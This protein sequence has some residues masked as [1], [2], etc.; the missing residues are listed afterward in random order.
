MT[1]RC[2]ASRLVHAGVTEVVDSTRVSAA[3]KRAVSFHYIFNGAR[4]R[5][6]LLSLSEWKYV[7]G[8]RLR[9]V[10]GQEDMIVDVA[11]DLLKT[12]TQAGTAQSRPG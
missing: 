10:G 6:L 2:A 9:M 1:R 5:E 8:G 12:H 4:E 11:L 7:S 3:T